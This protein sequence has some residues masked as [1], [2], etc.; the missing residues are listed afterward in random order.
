MRS[1]KTNPDNQHIVPATYLKQWRLSNDKN[2]VA[3]IDVSNQY[4]I[5]A[6]EYSIKK[7]ADFKIFQFYNDQRE[8]NPYMV[9]NI[10][11]VEY[12]DYYP[13]LISDVSLEKNP[14]I[15]LRKQIIEWLC[16]TYLRKPEQRM[17]KLI[18][19]I[20][21]VMEGMR[22]RKPV[23]KDEEASIK[24]VS[25]K[26][27]RSI[28]LD[29]LVPKN[30]QHQKIFDMF[31]SVLSCQKWKILKSDPNVRFWTSDNPGFSLEM[32]PLKMKE[33]PYIPMSIHPMFA[34]F[35]PL[36]PKYC[37]EITPNTSKILN[38]NALTDIIYYEDA[39]WQKMDFIN[40]GVL[41]TARK[42]VI[43][44]NKEILEK[45]IRRR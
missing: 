41:R 11:K 29:T 9:E 10:L 42:I 44:D 32:D 2:K 22:N 37:L 26:I 12:E 39:S 31:I 4:V 6:Q 45:C 34:I 35:F 19:E 3:G 16:I 38:Y 1:L 23:A 7:K 27:A 17:T 43:S 20:N 36:S 25:E 5:K 24:N 15:N 8:I 28:H 18:T 33:R 14:S 30:E 21:M 40:Q 13:N